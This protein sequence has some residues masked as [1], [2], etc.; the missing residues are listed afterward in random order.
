MLFI[1]CVF[2]VCLFVSL[3]QY[4]LSC[5]V[6]LLLPRPCLAPESARLIHRLYLS[7]L[8]LR[9]LMSVSPLCVCAVYL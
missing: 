8:Y 1:I 6:R 4:C 2:V 9:V 7:S 5:D 3:F